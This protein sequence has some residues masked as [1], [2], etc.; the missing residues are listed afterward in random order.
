ME[1][2]DPAAGSVPPVVAGPLGVHRATWPTVVGVL[3]VVLGSLGILKN[4]CGS[5]SGITQGV[6]GGGGLSPMG[7]GQY[8]AWA[9][10]GAAVSVLS[11][12]V[13][14]W[15]LWAGVLL[16][17]RRRGS[18][19]AHK[20]WAWAR[21]G[22]ALVEVLVS[23]V[24]QSVVFQGAW[25]SGGVGTGG[26]AGAGGAGGAATSGGTDTAMLIGML[27]V[28]AAF[29]LTLAL[30]YP[31]VVLVV[32]SRPWAKDEVKRWSGLHTCAA[33]GYNM[34]GLAPGA[35]CPE[36]GAARNRCAVCG[37][38]LSGVLPS[39]PCPDCRALRA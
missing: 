10:V 3:S 35:S 28:M 1:Q 19:A 36:C 18:V 34:Q 26:T 23:G 38:D 7:L 31:V 6:A 20:G 27:A 17:K 39:A 16:L 37:C 15:L 5:V 8:G 11:L 14:A 4:A 21:I 2:V 13:S 25:G 22:V 33:C 32:F 9:F 24:M 29:S 12:A 30:A